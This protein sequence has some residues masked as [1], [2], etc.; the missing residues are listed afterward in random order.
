MKISLKGSIFI[1]KDKIIISGKK[2]Q[3][4]LPEPRNKKILL[5]LQKLSFGLMATEISFFLKDYE[6]RNLLKKLKRLELIFIKYS[7]Y[8]STTL[9]K[10]YDFFSY[11]LSNNAEPFDFLKKLHIAIIG[12]GGTGANVALCLA[13]S[14]VSEL[15]LIDF[16]LLDITNLNR[17]FAYDSD[18]IGEYKVKQLNEKLLKLNP[19]LKINIFT[20]KINHSTDL[21]ILPKDI[22]FIVAAIDTP[23]IKSSIYIVEYALDIGTP[24]ILGAV[25]YDSLSA[26]PLLTTPKSKEKYLTHLYKIS[27]FQAS[28]ISGSMPST[29]LLLSAILANNIV[30]WFYPFAPVDLINTRKV[31]DP[32]TLKEL[33]TYYY[34]YI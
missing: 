6:C 3:Y 4:A 10:T 22:E 9:H 14:G 2:K 23:A 12:C 18:D 26:G 5:F 11:H 19:N 31:Y 32:F 15:T 29:N 7:K 24:V 34:D 17:Q 28:P 27:S 13:N 16:D 8:E 21:K 33:G 30:A 1:A 25:G 20:K